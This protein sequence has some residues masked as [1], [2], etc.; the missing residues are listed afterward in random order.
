[1]ALFSFVISTISA[2]TWVGPQETIRHKYCGHCG[3]DNVTNRLTDKRQCDQH[4]RAPI[5]AIKV[6]FFIVSFFYGSYWWKYIVFIRHV[7]SKFQSCLN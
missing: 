1:M 4:Y 3:Y 5:R 2:S 7:G 6:H